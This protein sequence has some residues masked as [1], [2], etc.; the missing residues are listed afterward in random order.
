MLGHLFFESQHFPQLP[1][2]SAAPQ[3]Q[4][5]RLWASTCGLELSRQILFEPS[6]AAL[7][8]MNLLHSSFRYRKN[9]C[10]ARK[11]LL[12][13]KPVPIPF[14]SASPTFYHLPGEARG[15]A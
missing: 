5:P 11:F 8:G 15:Q 2:A 10:V 13:Y 7:T 1:A 4:L 3:G 9:I 12:P 6:P 14:F